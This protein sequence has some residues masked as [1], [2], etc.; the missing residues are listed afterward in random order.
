MSVGLVTYANFFYFLLF[1]FALFE[2]QYPQSE[3][4]E[5]DI[6]DMLLSPALSLQCSFFL[7]KKNIS[8]FHHVIVF[9]FIFVLL[10]MFLTKNTMLLSL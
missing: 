6:S 8:L 2:R 4:V 9:P 1:L 3:Y 7:K 5:P 10:V